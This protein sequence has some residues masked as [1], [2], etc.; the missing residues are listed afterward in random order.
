MIFY[1]S[2][3]WH[4]LEIFHLWST[5]GPPKITFLS[6]DPI[7]FHWTSLGNLIAFPKLILNLKSVNIAPRYSQC[8]IEKPAKSRL[9]CFSEI[10]TFDC[11]ANQVNYWSSFE[12]RRDRERDVDIN[13]NHRYFF[14]IS[15]LILEPELWYSSRIIRDYLEL[16][17]YCFHY[18]ENLEK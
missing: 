6:S 15:I 5:L 8:S 11:W 17:Y 7:Y 1:E 3:I 9:V 16:H 13:E 4:K 2:N 12:R 14:T 10:W 18:S